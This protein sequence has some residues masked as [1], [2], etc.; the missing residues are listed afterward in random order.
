M[1][2]CEDL[3]QEL[4]VAIADN[5]QDDK[6]S[7]RAFSLVCKAWTNPA[8]DH[9]FASW[10]IRDFY[11]RLEK[12]K[13]ANIASTYTPY[14]RHLHLMVI[15]NRPKFWREVIPFLADFRTP[16][17]QSLS[18]C[19]L[20]WHD[21]SSNEQSA[22]LRRFESILSLQ[23]SLYRENP[24][25]DIATII[26]SFPRLRNLTLMPSWRECALPGLLPLSPELRLPERLST[27][28]VY[29]DSRLIL[30]C[31]CSIPEQLSIRTFRVLTRLTRPQD[32]DAV[33]MFLKAL[34]PSLE[35][36]G[37]HSDGMFMPSTPTIE[38]FINLCRL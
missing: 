35:A 13:T 22:L 30:E 38:R 34:G 37:C 10:T 17:L 14:L 3:P 29:Q 21:L 2:A 1:S 24:P 12:I 32:F 15:D 8:R 16:R 18:L 11:D 7:L 9:L 23:L 20:T 5:I 36:F 4:I 28:H 25:H 31:L 6:K 27:L 19:S 26:C 33:N